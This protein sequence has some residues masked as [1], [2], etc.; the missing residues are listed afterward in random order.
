MQPG[1]DAMILKFDGMQPELDAIIPGV[2]GMQPGLDAMHSGFNGIKPELD[3]IIPGFDGMQPGL[4]A[5]QP[6]L[7]KFLK[8]KKAVKK[9]LS[10]FFKDQVFTSEKI[11]EG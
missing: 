3:A 8:R 2:G 7:K 10:N 4:D 5:M 9:T 6:R 1:L 11:R